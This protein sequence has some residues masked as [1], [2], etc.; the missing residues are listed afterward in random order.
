MLAVI[1]RATGGPLASAEEYSR[2][3]VRWRVRR[4]S[5]SVATAEPHLSDAAM[6]SIMASMPRT[7]HPDLAEQI[8]AAILSS[9]KSRYRL[10]LETGIAQSTLSRF[11]HG[12]V[13]MTL[14]SAGRIV[15]ALDLELV[16]KQS[17]KAKK[18]TST[19]RGR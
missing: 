4:R 2:R 12:K 17:G 9:E 6:L 3:R 15:D 10:S 19:R 14:E 16:A 8:R 5:G 7:R 18:R 11:V 13:G 1:D